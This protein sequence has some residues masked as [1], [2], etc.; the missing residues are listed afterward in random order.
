MVV[1][2]PIPTGVFVFGL[3]SCPL[4]GLQLKLQFVRNQSN[5]FRIRGLSMPSPLGRGDRLRW[6]RF[7][8]SDLADARPPSPKGKAV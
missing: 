5:K 1:H 7:S 8:S 2:D 3:E 6:E 4:T